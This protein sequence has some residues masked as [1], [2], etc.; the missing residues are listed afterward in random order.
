MNATALRERTNGKTRAMNATT[1][2]KIGLDFMVQFFLA[3]H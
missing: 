3:T 1:I 2:G